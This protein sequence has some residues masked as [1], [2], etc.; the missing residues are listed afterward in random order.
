[1]SGECDKCGEH[2]LD[3]KCPVI[4]ERKWISKAEAKEMF[5]ESITPWHET[6]EGKQQLLDILNETFWFQ[7]DGTAIR[8]D[9][10]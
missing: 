9:E 10:F 2:C 3:C 6:E 7:P 8:K 4:R 5:P 1:M